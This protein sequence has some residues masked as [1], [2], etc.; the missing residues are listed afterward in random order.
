ML[1]YLDKLWLINVKYVM[2]ILFNDEIFKME[3]K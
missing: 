1:G 3:G 2:Q